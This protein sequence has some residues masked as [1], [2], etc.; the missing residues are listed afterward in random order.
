VRESRVLKRILRTNGTLERICG[1][2]QPEYRVCGSN[3]WSS[4]RI[5]IAVVS[6]LRAMSRCASVTVCVMSTPCSDELE[7]VDILGC[8]GT[9]IANERI[10]NVLPVSLNHFGAGVGIFFMELAP[11]AGFR[12]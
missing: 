1:K 3:D 7:G 4:R 11:V 5:A 8:A 9:G 6:I 10:I 12:S 2:V